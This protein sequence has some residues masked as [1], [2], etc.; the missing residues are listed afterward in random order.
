MDTYPRRMI[1]K[2][3]ISE[4]RFNPYKK[5][6]SYIKHLNNQYDLLQDKDI[7]DE[8]LILNKVF[9][10]QTPINSMHKLS[11]LPKSTVA[12]D[13]LHK[14][15]LV[16]EFHNL[17][18]KRIKKQSLQSQIFA[19][20]RRKKYEKYFK[21]KKY[22]DLVSKLGNKKSFLEGNQDFNENNINET[23]LKN[24]SNRFLLDR[25][26]GKLM[27]KPRYSSN[28]IEGSDESIGIHKEIQS[29]FISD[30]ILD[31]NAMNSNI[32]S[33]LS[34]NKLPIISK[35]YK[36]KRQSVPSTRTRSFKYRNIST[37]CS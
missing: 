12:K 18:E 16:E 14:M 6:R 13:I 34:V 24:R 31:I 21:G 22:S 27:Q 32:L 3:N 30:Q 17:S 28:K 15:H 29:F 7:Y 26:V 19:P 33:A 20:N 4:Q 35:Y 23:D 9:Q 36:S 11:L 2:N 8:S 1:S 5:A 10:Q 37:E 25:T